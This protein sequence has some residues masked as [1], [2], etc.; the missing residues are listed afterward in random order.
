MG[1]GI[2][3]EKDEQTI[4]SMTPERPEAA[5]ESTGP[6]ECAACTSSSLRI[7]TSGVCGGGG[8]FLRPR[9]AAINSV[10]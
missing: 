1:K 5:R 8:G 3:R 2:Q 9:P 6:K 7:K 4:H 10:V